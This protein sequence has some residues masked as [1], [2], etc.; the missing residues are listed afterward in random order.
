MQDFHCIILISSTHK[1]STPCKLRLLRIISLL[2]SIEPSPRR[3]S[4]EIAASGSRLVLKARNFWLGIFCFHVHIG[5]N[6]LFQ[7][8]FLL[9][10]VFVVGYIQRKIVFD[11]KFWLRQVLG[12][13]R[14]VPVL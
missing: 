4:K 3:E 9:L 8:T 6:K 14:F 2:G 5:K 12:F 1:C 10:K 7:Y 13:S 11:S